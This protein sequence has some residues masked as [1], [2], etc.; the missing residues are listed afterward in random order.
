MF[1][2]ISSHCPSF[3]NNCI[4][5]RVSDSLQ[6]QFTDLL[7]P[8][9][10]SY[11]YCCSSI[12]LHGGFNGVMLSDTIKLHIPECSQFVTMEA[13]ESGGS[14]S[15]NT[16]LN[17]NLCEWNSLTGESESIIC[18]LISYGVTVN[19]FNFK[20]CNGNYITRK[21]RSPLV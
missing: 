4:S 9:S 1:V 2:C 19:F 7:K 21:T 12:Y 3:I 8:V 11:R 20:L 16:S 18:F 13:C 15:S 6:S 17:F 14:F 5:I 10:Y